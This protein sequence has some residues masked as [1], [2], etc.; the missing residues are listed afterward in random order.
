MEILH[1]SHSQNNYGVAGEKLVHAATCKLFLI[2]I[3]WLQSC[4]GGGA[5]KVL[6][7]TRIPPELV[8]PRGR[9]LKWGI[10][11]L[12][13]SVCV[14]ILTPFGYYFAADFE[15]GFLRDKREFFFS[16]GYFIAFYTHIVGAPAAF[17]SG[18][19]QVSRTLRQNWPQL[20]RWLGRFYCLA[21]LTAAA[22]GGLVM[23]FWAYG[24]LSSQVCFSLLAGL[25]WI[26]T[27]LGW[28]F[29]RIGQLKKHAKWV[30][31]SYL[32]IASA[33]CLRLI[34]PLLSELQLNHE[35][36]YQLAVW[37]SWVLPLALF[38]LVRWFS[39]RAKCR[40]A[41]AVVVSR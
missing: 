37:A 31:R 19:L 22:P 40:C 9:Y 39:D 32:L 41:D 3:L 25:T 8:Q 34:H 2:S 18:T 12:A 10:L 5:S 16:S 24:G 1:C 13:V 30:L 27:F 26:A 20:H 4:T 28:R 35:L 7:R 15:Y 14:M 33:I 21:V 36:T 38:E 17:L 11:T 29:A 6:S 23:G